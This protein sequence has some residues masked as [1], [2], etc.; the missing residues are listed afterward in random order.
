ML[1]ARVLVLNA[2]RELRGLGGLALVCRHRDQ[3]G[4]AISS[5]DKGERGPANRFGRDREA[6][7]GGATPRAGEREHGGV[8]A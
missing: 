2:P 6:V 3:C 8:W 7:Q 1:C 4:K 5:P